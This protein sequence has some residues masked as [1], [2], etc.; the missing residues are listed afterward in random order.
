VEVKAASTSA[1]MHL[2]ATY[3][4]L[5]FLWRLWEQINEKRHNTRARE[6]E[7]TKRAHFSHSSDGEQQ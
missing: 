6:V 2:R 7:S 5:F 4:K 3:K 1:G